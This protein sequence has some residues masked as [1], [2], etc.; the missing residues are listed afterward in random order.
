MLLEALSKEVAELHFVDTR[1][2][3]FLPAFLRTPL[4]AGQMGL[5]YGK[6]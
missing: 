4:V 5:I 2:N 1:K 3:D 6:K